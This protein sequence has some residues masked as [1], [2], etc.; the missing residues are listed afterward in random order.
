MK[1]FVF[2]YSEDT[3]YKAGFEA[4]TL[5]EAQSLLEAHFRGDSRSESFGD[6][7]ELP[8]FWSKIKGNDYDYAPETLEEAN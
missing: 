7:E 1:D 3:A 4:E 8:G 6:L 5:E 2:W